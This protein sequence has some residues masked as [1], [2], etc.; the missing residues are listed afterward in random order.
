MAC[1]S[2]ACWARP[3]RSW[4]TSTAPASLASARIALALADQTGWRPSAR[5]RSGTWR[6]LRVAGPTDW[7][8]TGSQDGVGPIALCDVP[9]MM[10]EH[11]AGHRQEI[12][13]VAARAR[14]GAEATGVRGGPARIA[15][16]PSAS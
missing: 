10:A 3:I 6:A 14:A 11:D 7:P 16:R 2:S 1:A 8:R 4:P 12:D 13:G 9:A 15:S 5:A